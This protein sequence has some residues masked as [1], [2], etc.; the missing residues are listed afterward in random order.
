MASLAVFLVSAVVALSASTAVVFAEQ[1]RT[2]RQKD[3]AEEAAQQASESYHITRGLTGEL[4]E[5]VENR[6]PRV[7]GAEPVRKALLD[8]A[9][10]AFNRFLARR[11]EDPDL[12]AWTARLHRFSANVRRQ[13]GELDAAEPLYR[14]AIRLEEALAALRP[15]DTDNRDRLA[16]T[17]RDFASLPK[18]AGRLS[19]ASTC[20]D[21]SAEVA[22]NLLAA[23]PG[24]GALPPHARR[25]AV[26]AIRGA[27]PARSARRVAPIGRPRRR[28]VPKPARRRGDR[29][30][31]TGPAVVRHRPQPSRGRPPSWAGPTRRWCRHDEAAAQLTAMLKSDNNADYLHFLA[32][33]RLDQAEA[34]R[35]RRGARR[36]SRPG[37]RRG[38]G[39]LG[40]LT[41]S[42]PHT[43]FYREFH[44]LAHAARGERLLA[45]GEATS[46]GKHLASARELLQKLVKENPRQASWR[47]NLGRVFAATGRHAEAE[48]EAGRAAEW[49]R[50]AAEEPRQARK[51]AP[52]ND[53]DRQELEKV[54]KALARLRASRLRRA[55]RFRAARRSRRSGRVGARPAS[56]GWGSPR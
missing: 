55:G 17:W 44:A 8:A 30:T 13:M 47:A 50:R 20:L 25:H 52:E 3:R 24:V 16:Q 40:R 10:P 45:S 5:I 14:E 36:P 38:S 39:H 19:E 31:P 54:E 15:D 9:L 43:P 6:L 26:G 56:S 53:H 11:P 12:M 51:Q 42:Y 29:E 7:A 46:A 33:T 27:V 22:E 35:R 41:R 28:P 34:L 49:Y 21:R 23:N 37:P 32:R 18:L 48:G 4:V 1:R 2:E